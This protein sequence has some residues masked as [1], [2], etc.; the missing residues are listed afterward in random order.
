M[1]V[2][3]LQAILRKYGLPFLRCMAKFINCDCLIGVD[4]LFPVAVFHRLLKNKM[5]EDLY[6]ETTEIYVVH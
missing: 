5:R 4:I 3:L 1:I 6:K 2:T